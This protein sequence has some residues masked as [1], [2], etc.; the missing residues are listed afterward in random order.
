MRVCRESYQF[1]CAS[2]PFGLKL[3]MRDLGELV[4]DH[5]PS[6][7]NFLQLSLIVFFNSFSNFDWSFV[8]DVIKNFSIYPLCS[9]FEVTRWTG[10]VKISKVCILDTV[11]FVV[12]ALLFYVHGKHLRS[13]RDGQL[14][15]PH[16]SWAGLDL[17]SG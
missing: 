7:L 17:L 12:V 3:G 6:F 13:W 9:F 5:C 15:Y 8:H 11:G 14:T 1:V 4:P 16:F 10:G 2:F